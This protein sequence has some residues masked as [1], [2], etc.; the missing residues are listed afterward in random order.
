MT[1]VNRVLYPGAIVAA[2]LLV[3]LLRLP[4]L[5]LAA[6]LASG[7]IDGRQIPIVN[8]TPLSFAAQTRVLPCGNLRLEV[9]DDAI[10]EPQPPDESCGFHL[11]LRGLECRVPPPRYQPDEQDTGTTDWSAELDR[12][13][14]DW[15]ASVCAASSEDFSFWMSS[16]QAE[17]L[18]Q[19]LQAKMYLSLFAERIEV[20]RSESLCGLLV[21]WG[22]A[23]QPRMRLEYFTPDRRTRGTLLITLGASTPEAMDMARAIV[24]SL[25]VERALDNQASP[26]DAVAAANPTCGRQSEMLMP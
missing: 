12:Y 19:R 14:I 22:L 26:N 21:M 6:G 23:D 24:S 7:Q 11:K 17:S 13:G 5:L 18:R 3:V 9:P 15:Q 16:R 10:I 2:G 25:R 20:V 4:H 1:D 8:M